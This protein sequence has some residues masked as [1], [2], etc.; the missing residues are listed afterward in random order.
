MNISASMSRAAQNILSQDVLATQ[1]S[2]SD[3]VQ[4]LTRSSDHKYQ[5]VVGKVQSLLKLIGDDDVKY[6]TLLDALDKMTIDIVAHTRAVAAQAAAS[7]DV[8]ESTG[9]AKVN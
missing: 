5:I 3:D 6:Q 8:D 4:V 9:E 1:Q 7:K 2:Q